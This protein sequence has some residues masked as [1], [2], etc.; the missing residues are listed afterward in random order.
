VCVCVCVR[1]REREREREYSL[2]PKITATPYEQFAFFEF[3]MFRF[4]IENNF[5]MIQ[6]HQLVVT[7][8]MLFIVS[9]IYSKDLGKENNFDFLT[10][11]NFVLTKEIFISEIKLVSEIKKLKRILELNQNVIKQHRTTSLNY[12]GSRKT[13]NLQVISGY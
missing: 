8:L 6:L 2:L 9:I 4:I 11:E 13:L 5:K 1:E 7:V 10:F 3:C 12:I